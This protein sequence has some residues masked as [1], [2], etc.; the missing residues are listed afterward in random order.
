MT[1]AIIGLLLL[2]WMGCRTPEILELS[3]V[4]LRQPAPAESLRYRAA[5][6]PS[7]QKRC[8]RPWAQPFAFLSSAEFLSTP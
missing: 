2:Y 8:V 1:I 4:L 5:Q 7:R 3:F 6:I